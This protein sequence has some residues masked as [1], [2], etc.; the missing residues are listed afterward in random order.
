MRNE[1]NDRLLRRLLA[2]QQ[3]LLVR[4]IGDLQRIIWKIKILTKVLRD[5]LYEFYII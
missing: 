1:R 2:V 4:N 3:I 5:K